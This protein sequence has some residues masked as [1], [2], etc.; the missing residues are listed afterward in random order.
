MGSGLE[1]AW[2]SILLGKNPFHHVCMLWRHGKKASP[3]PSSPFAH[4]PFNYD[5]FGRQLPSDLQNGLAWASFLTFTS[6]CLSVWARVVPGEEPAGMQRGAGGP[7]PTWPGSLGDLRHP[8]PAACITHIP[9]HE[10]VSHMHFCFF[11]FL[12][13]Q[14]VYLISVCLGCLL[15]WVSCHDQNLIIS[16]DVAVLYIGKGQWSIAAGSNNAG[17][18]TKAPITSLQCIW[19][20]SVGGLGVILLVMG[21]DFFNSC[22]LCFLYI[23][24]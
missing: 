11:L 23:S 16:S 13:L 7:S 18:T 14:L 9:T 15:L 5:D 3:H 22:P 1:G 10:L 17:K 2:R 12:C 20:E 8:A 19:T 21:M 24:V 4:A 6:G